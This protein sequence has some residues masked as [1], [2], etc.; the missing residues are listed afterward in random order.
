MASSSRNLI[1]R[2]LGSSAGFV[3]TSSISAW[4]GGCFSVSR[5]RRLALPP[6][7]KCE[8][9]KLRR[10]F[11]PPQPLSVDNCVH[12]LAATCP[13]SCSSCDKV[14]GTSQ[15]LSNKKYLVVPLDQSE[16]SIWTCEY[17]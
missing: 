2:T 7:T 4:R 16:R 5:L 10:H 15:T 1:D 8:A 9:T 17:Y 13:F 12:R 11:P 14:R 3:R 6:S